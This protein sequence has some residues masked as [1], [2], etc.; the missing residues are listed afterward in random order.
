MSSKITN[1]QI[2]MLYEEAKKSGALGG[3]L[4]G[5]GGGGYLLIF[6]PYNVR[7]KVAARL[8]AAGGQIA[9]WNFELRGA[10]SWIADEK[11]WSYDSVQVHLPN[12]NY[13]FPL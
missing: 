5:A 9:D 1:P 3:K 6:C 4:L 2:D 12:G 8:E 7:H 11:R 13:Q 10:Q